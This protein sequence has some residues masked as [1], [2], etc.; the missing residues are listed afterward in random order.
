MKTFW[1]ALVIVLL[2]AGCG[3]QPE[4]CPV[5]ERGECSGFAFRVTLADGREVKTCCARCGLHYLKLH[6][7]TA[8]SL[9]ATDYS[10][11]RWINAKSAVFVSCSD[12][13]PCARMET[14]RD[15]QGCCFY[16]GYDR[17]QPSLV[18]FETRAAARS[19]QQQHGGV[20]LALEQLAVNENLR[21]EGRK[22]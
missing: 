4:N 10:S 13:S 6:G 1:A 16:K 7:Q 8:T 20:L 21:E 19:F 22:P 2:A 5:C 17:C 18:A 15:S 14:M 12:V 3:R 11:G 9:Q